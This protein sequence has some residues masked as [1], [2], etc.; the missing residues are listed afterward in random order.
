ML[1]TVTSGFPNL[2]ILFFPLSFK[3]LHPSHPIPSH[4]TS[5]TIPFH[6]YIVAITVKKTLPLALAL[7]LSP[8][9]SLFF[10]P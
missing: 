3:T 7:A 10:R 6:S 9:P 5:H 2:Q 4:P 8:T 1:C